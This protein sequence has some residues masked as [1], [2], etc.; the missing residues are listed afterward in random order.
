VAK[1]LVDLDESALQ[2]AMLEFGTTTKVETVNR[3]LREVASRRA[4]NLDD[5][6]ATALEISDNLAECDVRNLAWQ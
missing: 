3:A 2:A 1:T 6:M 5:L 4:A